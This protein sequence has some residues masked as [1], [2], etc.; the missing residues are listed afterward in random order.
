MTAIATAG[1]S[2]ARLGVVIVN[3]RRAADTIE[4]LESL[5]RSTIPLAVVVVDN[6]SGDGSGDTI[7]AWAAGSLAPT[8]ANPA[9]AALTAPPLPKPLL[10]QRPRPGGS[11]AD[12]G[13]GLTLIEAP[14]NLGF[15]GGNNL[16]LRQ[17]L[18][19]PGIEAFWLLNNDTVVAPDTAERL[20]AA[21]AAV[22]G[23]GM[24]GTTVR[25]YW[26]PDRVQALGGS[27]FF[28]LTGTSRS[29][30][31]GQ[32]ATDPVDA[33]AVTAAMDFVLGASLAASRRF[34]ETIGLMEESYFL[35]FEE[36]DWAARNRRHRPPFPTGFAPD[37]LVW[38][39][40]GGSIGSSGDKA[41]RSP[42]SDYWLT[43]SRLAYA[44]R[45][46]PTLRP[47]Y[48]ALSVGVAARRLARRQPDKARAIMRALFGREY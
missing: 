5:L 47:W 8:A 37:A 43:R 39:K 22:S 45:F 23:V 38:H 29:I 19:D 2:R 28:P 6:A 35:Y 40:E 9:L 16:G 10:L 4:C 18:A 21:M 42:L 30:G 14:K 27:R 46:A 20:L 36:L 32:A 44:R 33:A 41:R 3:Y 12:P 31:G 25:Y 11:A 34:L 24:C 48:W 17:L 1:G 15:A 7:A 26:Q 13:A